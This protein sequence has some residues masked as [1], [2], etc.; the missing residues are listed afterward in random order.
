M[1]PVDWGW[2]LD[3]NTLMPVQMKNNDAPDDLLKVI[4][5]N[6]KKPYGYACSCRKAGLQ[7]TL[8]CGFCSEK[9]C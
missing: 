8:V 1:P 9:N 5:C 3:N 7:C 4:F 2:K 6:C